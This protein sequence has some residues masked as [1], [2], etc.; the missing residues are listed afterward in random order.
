LLISLLIH[1]GGY[2]G[3]KLGEAF[4]LWNKLKLPAWLRRAELLAQN[5]L[6][7][8]PPRDLP[9]LFVDVNPQVATAEAPKNAQYE[10]DKNS[11][12]GNPDVDKE[13]GQPKI[14]GKQLDIVKAED[15]PRTPFDRLQPA[16]SRSQ[17]EQPAERARPN[18]PANPGDLAMVKP[19]PPSRPDTGTAE[20][21]R[22]RTI[23]EAM[24]R[25]NRNQLAGEKMKQDAGVR[26]FQVVASFDAKLTAFG[27]YDAAFIEAVE[28][29]W[30]ALLDSMSYDGYRHG[31]VVL[32]FHLNYDGR[33]TEMKV[34]ENN[35]G[36]TLG[37]LCQ[38]AVLDPAPFEKWT[39]EMRLQLDKDYRDIQFAFYYN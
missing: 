38:K 19:D 20:Q 16:V 24:M 3:Y 34:V 37:L 31:R 39:R 17:T 21:S 28:Q 33:I 13:T 8:Q 23:K 36:E 2:G 32:Q 7:N 6:T 5:S 35:V 25:Q 18:T 9:M 22:P 11:Q 30:F 27:M 29:R 26:R 14:D 12:A 10:S 1:A 15:V 4:D